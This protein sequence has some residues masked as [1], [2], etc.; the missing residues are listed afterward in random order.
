MLLWSVCLGCIEERIVPDSE[1]D[2]SSEMIVD[3]EQD[4]GLNVEEDSGDLR[5][6]QTP[7]L[8]VSAC[9]EDPDFVDC[10]N[11]LCLEHPLCVEGAL[12]QPNAV[13]D[14]ALNEFV[15]GRHVLDES[16][17]TGSCVGEGLE[18]VFQ[19]TSTASGPVCI[20][21]QG[22]ESDTAL[23]VRTR[24]DDARSE[25]ACNDDFYDLNA[26][27]TLEAA[28]G[29]VYFIFVDQFSLE[30]P[31]VYQLKI[32]EGPCAPPVMEE[33]PSPEEVE[34]DCATLGDE[35]DNGLAECD[36]RACLD[37][38]E[39]AQPLNPMAC[40]EG[41]VTV[42]ETW[43][44]YRGTTEGATDELH[45]SCG[46]QSA[47]EIIYRFAPP[48][49]GAFCVDTLGSTYDTL[50]HVRKTC[51]D[52][53]SERYC[54]D[55]YGR[56]Q[57]AISVE[58]QALVPYFL[59]VDGYRGEGDFE[60]MISEG[61]C[62]PIPREDCSQPGDEDGN[63]DADCD[64]RACMNTEMCGPYPPE[65]CAP[66]AI[67]ELILNDDYVSNNEDAPRQTLGSC[68][69]RGREQVYRF[70]PETSGTYCANTFGSEYDTVLYIRSEC[71]DPETELVCND[72][73]DGIR[74]AVTFEAEAQEPLFIF[75]DS[76]RGRPGTYTLK[77]TEG[78][79]TLN[80]EVCTRPGDDDRNG[81]ADCEDPA[82]VDHP[83]CE[84]PQICEPQE[85]I[86]INTLGAYQGDTQD[87]TS[88]E[89]GSCGGE[90]A[91]A[92][93]TFSVAGA[94]PLCLSTEGSSV[95]TVLYVRTDCGD[96][97][98]EVACNDDYIGLDAALTLNAEAGITYY[99]FVD[100]FGRSG[101]FN[102]NL[103]VG[104]CAPR[105]V[106]E[107]CDLNG[108]EDLN[109]LADC[110]DPACADSLDCLAPIGALACDPSV[111][112][113]AEAWGAYRGDSSGAPSG[114]SGSCGG[115]G[116]QEQVYAV[117]PPSAGLMCAQVSDAS[118][119][120]ALHA[121]SACADAN[122]ELGCAERSDTQSDGTFSA[123]LEL[124]AEAG[125]TYYLFVDGEG[126]GP[127]EL[128]LSVGA[129]ADE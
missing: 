116:G 81:L 4:Q 17:A 121:R 87:Q 97:S 69:G 122:S 118:F 12:C 61:A 41:A 24:C 90:G 98:S 29:E 32:I 36:D 55:D 92:V 115:E 100:S 106:P 65:A 95:D 21:T 31:D 27:L 101:D 75:A 96:A 89:Q 119:E 10:D 57:A 63:G 60:I 40:E 66:E 82:C 53:M 70:V 7:D 62:P 9:S 6:D 76:F 93:Y 13:I 108:D 112:I 43:G 103:S 15:M 80:Y 48:S 83:V 56:T 71:A 113:S 123:Q 49:D 8:D 23:Y 104:A 129:C 74:A 59:I 78:S 25:I 125:Q 52:P 99:V 45:G 1:R 39:C 34:E 105:S 18:S 110:D 109:G 44:T 51:N 3:G 64:D 14:I 67:T 28:E 68:A 33:P 86:P 2:D 77:V 38:P 16:R 84:L 120:V 26:A 114:E 19:F 47:G 11:P 42:I 30:S 88:E 35:D 117:T 128:I 73:F 102:L 72:D 85:L 79:C 126:S 54:N 46:G 124:N 50:L 22:A 94:S 127:Y 37:R 20:T 111:L 91:E 107:R 5:P 58:G